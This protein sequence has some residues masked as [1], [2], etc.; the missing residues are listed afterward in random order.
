[1]KDLK[2]TLATKYRME[3]GQEGELLKT[4]FCQELQNKLKFMLTQ[5]L[6]E[7]SSKQDVVYQFT[8]FR[9]CE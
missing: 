5:S 3:E 1:M 7:K 8:F 6:I 9:K 4:R 2:E